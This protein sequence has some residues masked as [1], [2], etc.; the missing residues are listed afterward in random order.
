MKNGKFVFESGEKQQTF[1]GIPVLNRYKYLGLWLDYKLQMDPQM[2]HIKKKSQYVSSKLYLMIVN[3][4]LETRIN[5]WNIFCRP[6]IEQTFALF[7]DEDSR[8]NKR[9]LLNLVRSTFRKMTL[10][11]NRVEIAIIDKFMGYD[12]EEHCKNAVKKA[13]DKWERRMGRSTPDCEGIEKEHNN[14]I[15][16]EKGIKN[17]MPKELIDYANI[18]TAKCTKCENTIARISHLRAVH[19]LVIPDVIELWDQ[20]KN[21]N[22]KEKKFRNGVAIAVINRKKTI[23]KRTEIAKKYYDSITEL[24]NRR[25]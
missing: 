19:N 15:R 3:C 25:N 13:K 23:A 16:K 2:Q 18:L 10:L 12:I 6:L 11:S 14:H 8:S 1:E 9:N 22:I 7:Y 24:L 17:L 4:S 5:F 21:V 20:L